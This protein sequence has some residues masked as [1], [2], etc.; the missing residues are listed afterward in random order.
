MPGCCGGARAAAGRVRM[1]G[2]FPNPA[3]RG[4]SA[5]T[6]QVPMSFT[7]PAEQ[8]AWRAYENVRA[9]GQPVKIQRNLYNRAIAL[10]ARG[11][12]PGTVGPPGFEPAAPRTGPLGLGRA[13]TNVSTGQDQYSTIPPGA[14]PLG[15]PRDPSSVFETSPFT[16]VPTP[17]ERAPVPAP[18]PPQRDPPTFSRYARARIKKDLPGGPVAVT[19]LFA[20]I[21]DPNR[22]GAVFI[23]T[24]REVDIYHVEREGSTFYHGFQNPGRFTFVRYVGPTCQPGQTGPVCTREIGEHW[25]WVFSYMLDELLGPFNRQTGTGQAGTHVATGQFS[26]VIERATP[27]GR[28]QAPGTVFT[29]SPFQVPVQRRSVP[30]DEP[31]GTPPRVVLGRQVRLRC[32]ASGCLV[33]ERETLFRRGKRGPFSVFHNG[34]VGTAVELGHGTI[35]VPHRGVGSSLVWQAITGDWVLVRLRARDG[36]IHTGWVPDGNVGV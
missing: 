11:A 30:F 18:A 35:L 24:D 12:G 10:R 3:L 4:A 26:R 13:R 8:A 17:V 31:A 19:P 14:G 22:A 27:L 25:G 21:D 33:M 5:S 2:G 7:N 16:P 6:G 9:S 28:Q 36:A 34:D 15:R 23:P 32:G 29:S 20:A 1:L